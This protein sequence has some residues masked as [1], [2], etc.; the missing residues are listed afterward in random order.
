MSGACGAN[1]TAATTTPQGWVARALSR[2]THSEEREYAD[3]YTKRD[4]AVNSDIRGGVFQQST[5]LPNRGT[6]G[7]AG[8]PNVAT[9]NGRST[10]VPGRASAGRKR[11]SPERPLPSKRR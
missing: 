3:D 1:Y 11:Q 8:K 9:K 10:P 7:E 4:S 5:S 2:G 6:C